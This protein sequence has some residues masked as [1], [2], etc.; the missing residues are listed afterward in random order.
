MEKLSE[1]ILVVPRSRGAAQRLFPSSFSCRFRNRKP[2]S[3][4]PGASEFW[5]KLLD[6]Y[7]GITLAADLEIKSAA[8]R[9]RLSN[10]LGVIVTNLQAKG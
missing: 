8:I 4:L 7:A 1:C 2:R 5:L 6:D 9:T 10:F 3:V